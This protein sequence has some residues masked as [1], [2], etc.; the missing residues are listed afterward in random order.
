M[1]APSVQRVVVNGIS[2][3]YDDWA[4]EHGPLV[5]IPSITGHKGTFTALAEQ[6]APQFRVLSLDQRGRCDSPDLSGAHG[7]GFSYHARD[8]LAFADALQ[9]ERFI[10]VGHSFG[11]TA[12]V[13][14]ASLK[15]ERVSALVLL[16][17]GADPPHDTLRAMYPTIKRLSKTYRSMDEYLAAQRNVVYHKPWTPALEKYLRDE[18]TMMEDGSVRNKSSASAIE[19]DL[20]MHFW[21]NVWFHLPFLRCPVLFLRPTEGLLGATS[22]VYSDAD[23]SRLVS[24]IPQC[25]YRLVEGGN[26]YTF[27]IQDNPPVAQHIQTFLEELLR[28]L[29]RERSS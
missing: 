9:L 12:S 23:A 16:D 3:A 29:T 19:H 15:P 13:Y 26:H 22:H 14:T 21:E 8:I 4:G 25:T 20:D 27:V 28:A 18:M 10:L 17:G 11:A 2:L 7:Y 6:L 1:S 24:Q 5:C